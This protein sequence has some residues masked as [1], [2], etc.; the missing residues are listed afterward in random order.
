MCV[1]VCEC[2]CVCL[3]LVKFSYSLPAITHSVGPLPFL[4]NQF[5]T[6]FFPSSLP[7][8]HPLRE[9]ASAVPGLLHWEGN[10]PH[11]GRNSSQTERNH[12]GFLPRCPTRSVD[13]CVYLHAC[14][15]IHIHIQCTCVYV[16][17]IY[18]IMVTRARINYRN[19]KYT[20]C[21]CVG[22]GGGICVHLVW[23]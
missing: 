9:E 5:Q 7:L 15:H 13:A 1:C 11:S 20:V 23:K 8:R 4:S 3:Q 19:F 12:Y 6:P 10:V 21:V 17:I 2:V 16:H 22:G 18:N 14:I